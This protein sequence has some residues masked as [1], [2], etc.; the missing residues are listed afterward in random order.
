MK[1]KMLKKIK[2]NPLLFWQIYVVAFLI[3]LIVLLFLTTFLFKRT[4]DFIDGELVEIEFKSEV[5][6]K[7]QLE[8]VVSG[9]EQKK[10]VFDKILLEG[11]Q[12]SDPSL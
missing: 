9:L 2:F 11:V 1:I 5:I 12:V 4:A 3:A 7:E 8:E 10:A 6:K